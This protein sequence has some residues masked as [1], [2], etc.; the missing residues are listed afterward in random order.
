MT[1]SGA[2]VGGERWCTRGGVARW[3][4]GGVVYRVFRPGLGNIGDSGSPRP[5]CA[6]LGSMRPVDA[7]H[8]PMVPYSTCQGKLGL[9]PQKLVNIP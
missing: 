3:V 8:P 1:A 7:W 4:P 9:D 6:L 5:V 2:E